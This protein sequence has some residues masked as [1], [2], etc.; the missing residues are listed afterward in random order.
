MTAKKDNRERFIELLSPESKNF[1]NTGLS[2]HEFMQLRQAESLAT[3]WCLQTPEE[4][5]RRLAIVVQLSVE[6]AKIRE[7]TIAATRIAERAIEAV[8]EGDWKTVQDHADW[9]KPGEILEPPHHT[10]YATFR[11]LLLQALRTEKELPA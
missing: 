7:T 4:K 9:L 2:M 5:K 1:L 8:I 11:E 10:L 6:L 3:S